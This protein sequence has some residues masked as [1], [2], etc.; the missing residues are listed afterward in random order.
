MKYKLRITTR[1]S[2]STTHELECHYICI[3]LINCISQLGSQPLFSTLIQRVFLLSAFKS[4]FKHLI[5]KE[6]IKNYIELLEKW[7][8]FT[9]V[10]LNNELSCT[11]N[12]CLK[13]ADKLF[14]TLL[15]NT[16]YKSNSGLLIL[17]LHVHVQLCTYIWES[18]YRQEVHVLGYPVLVNKIISLWSLAN[19]T[20]GNILLVQMMNLMWKDVTIYRKQHQTHC[21]ALSLTSPIL[22]VWANAYYLHSG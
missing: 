18:H 7:G 20:C 16:F 4:L 1:T 13:N 8:T 3:H 9:F 22:H 17:D 10:K 11:V 19:I 15:A 12:A 5:F 21:L 6:M 14:D 2:Q